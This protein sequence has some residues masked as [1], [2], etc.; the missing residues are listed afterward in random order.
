MGKQEMTLQYSPRLGQR[1]GGTPNPGFSIWLF[2]SG[3]FPVPTITVG[4][5]TETR[6]HQEKGLGG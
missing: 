2:F 4:S 6:E 5:L 3:K 1:L